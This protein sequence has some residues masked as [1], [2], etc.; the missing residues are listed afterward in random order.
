MVVT[1]TNNSARAH[2]LEWRVEDA[3]EARQQAQAPAIAGVAV[4]PRVVM[5]PPLLVAGRLS[6]HCTLQPRAT[7]AL[8]LSLT[9]LLCGP[10]ALPRVLLISR[11]TGQR[12]GELADGGTLFV[13]PRS[14]SLQ[15]RRE[16]AAGVAAAAAAAGT[17]G[18]PLLYPLH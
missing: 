4:A 14:A 12:V 9:P 10:V 16:S 18:M 8:R 5:T 1:A 17:T 2:S 11:S 13:E 3:L 7:L 15:R 6:G